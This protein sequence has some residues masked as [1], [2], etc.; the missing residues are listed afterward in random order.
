MTYRLFFEK[1]SRFHSCLRPE[2]PRQIVT[3]KGSQEGIKPFVDLAF[4]LK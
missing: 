1:G 4:E 2:R 3:G